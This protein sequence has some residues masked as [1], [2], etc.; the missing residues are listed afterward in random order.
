M[1]DQQE[2]LLVTGLWWNDTQ[3]INTEDVTSGR[4]FVE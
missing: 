4:N 3:R 2:S 1:N